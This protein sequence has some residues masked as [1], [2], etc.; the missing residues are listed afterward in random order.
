MFG[1]VRP[2]RGELKVRALEQYQADYC[3][4]CRSLGKHFGFAARFTVS[5]DLLF[6]YLILSGT[7]PE[8]ERS[9]CRCPA[10]PWRC[11]ACAPGAMCQSA[12]TSAGCRTACL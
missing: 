5:Y 1:Y 4:L 10:K 6:L 12:A 7:E 3:G 9:R 11:R 2:L 8:A